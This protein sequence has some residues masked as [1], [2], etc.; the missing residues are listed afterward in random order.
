MNHQQTDR[1]NDKLWQ[2]RYVDPAGNYRE[3]KK[4]LG[5]AE[6]AGYERGMAYAWL[7]MA[8]ACFLRS[9]NREAFELVSRLIEYFYENRE[10]P[11]YAW[12]LNLQA[13]LFESLGDYEKGLSLALKA[14]KH[15]GERAD[16]E[17]EADAASILGLVYS[18]L[19]NCPRAIDYYKVA[20]QIREEQQ[21][22]AGVA[23]SL[24]RLG[25]ISRL[26]GDH[27]KALEYYFSSLEI[28][29]QNNLLS[30]VPWTMLGIASTYEEMGRYDDALEY[31][32][33]GLSDS[34]KRC[35]LQCETGRG[36]IYGTLGDAG[37][38]EDALTKALQMAEELDARALIAGIQMALSGH[39]EK[40]GQPAKALDAWKSYQQAREVLMS[41]EAQNRLMNVEITHAV[42]KSEQEKE[43][44][45]LRNVEL[46]AAYDSIDEKNRE[47]TASINYA[48]YIQE[49]ILPRPEEI[50]WLDG[51][52][53]ILYLPKDIVSGDFY[54]FTEKEGNTVITAADCTGH[55]VPG[56]LMSMLGVSL[57]EEIVSRRGIIKAGEILD[58]LRTEVIRSLK[59]TGLESGSKD[60]M[61]LSLC[62]IGRERRSLQY[63]G[64]YNSLYLVRESEITEIKADRMPVA[65]HHD[66]DKRFTTHNIPVKP[67]DMI[68]LCSDGFAD[69]FGGPQGK[70]FRARN[71]AELFVEFSPLPAGQQG[72]ML[73]EK[74]RGWKVDLEQ[75]DDVVVLGIRIQ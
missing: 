16:H 54:W 22:H 43:I 42:E 23:S 12:T 4:I 72:R 13:G 70:K 60:G 59:Q 56:A 55:G 5:R 14:F 32:Q 2:N 45:R 29:R 10:E 40:L 34:D 8:T 71:L 47:I 52:M 41:E 17:A 20:L 21:D 15:A 1:L 31:Y 38:A 9:E 64:A 48:R 39:W 36:R 51:N 7:N 67:G 58:A 37:R 61:D 18:R 63:A 24:N 30:A 66:M 65:I 57:L 27:D 25:M 49:A 69:Q 3:A 28:R 68:Y 53:F 26:T 50:P 44:Y 74:Y 73:E 6:K 33:K 11:G 62:V 75:V 19:S 35:A 46:K